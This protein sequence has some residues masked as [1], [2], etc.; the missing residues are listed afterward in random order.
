[1]TSRLRRGGPLLALAALCYL[2]LLATSPGQ[3]V[4]DTKTY[5]YLDPGRLLSR[6]WSMWDAH[7]GMGTVTHQNIGFLW[8]MGP[9]YWAMEHL[10]A[11][12]WVAQRL[13]LGSIMFLAGAGVW[14]LLRT[15]GWRGPSVA[16]AVSAYALSPYLL[17]NAVRISAVLLPFTALPWL[18]GL[19]VRALRTAS[20]RHPAAFALVV[21]T[22]GTSNATA[23]IL[24]GVGPVLWLA[25]SLARRDAPARRVAGVVARVG[26][27]SLG[28]NA[29]WIAGLSVQATNGID[30]LRYTESVQVTAAASSAQE[31]LRGLGYW[32]FYG[33]DAI[34]PWVGPSRPYQTSPWLLAVTFAIP[35]LALTGGAVARWRE[36]SYFVLLATVGLV[37]AVGV[38]PYTDPPP[39]GR[40]AKAFLESDVGM[41]MRS[42]PRAA[43]LVVLAIAVMLGAGLQALSRRGPG[44][45]LPAVVAVVAL[46][47]LALPPLWQRTLAPANV[48]RPEAIPGYWV[49]AGRYLDATDDGTRALVVPGTDFTSYRWGTTFDPVLPGLTDRPLVARELQ[50]MGSPAAWNLL[51]AFDGRLQADLA[52][53]AT[54][55]PIARLMRAGQVL[56]R[57]DL[58]YEH[59][60][61][62]RP[63]R[64][65]ELVRGAPGLGATKSFGPPAPNVAAEPVP[66]LDEREL[67]LD[68]TLP[69]PPPVAVLPVDGAPPIVASQ[70]AEQP[71]VLAGDGDGVVDSAAA[72]LLT[73]TELVHYSAALSG[74][75]LQ[76]ALADGAALVV[77]DT[78][79]RRA[80]RW[81]TIRFTNGY[82]EPAGLR[83][84]RT[85]RSDARL[86]VFPMADDDARTV[87]LHRGGLTANATSYGGRN[88]YLPE[89][90]PANA[91]D[92]DASTAWRT[93]QDDPVRGERLRL[94]TDHP[95]TTSALTFLAPPPPINRWVTRVAL[96]F[97]GGPPLIVDLG[98]A[99]RTAPGQTV[100]IG[101]RTFSTLDIEVLADSAGPQGRYGGLTSTGF[102]EVVVGGLRLDEVVRPPTDLLERAGA[103]SADHPL[104]FVLSRLRSSVTDVERLDEELSLARALDL[105]TRRSFALSGTARLS[106][107]AGDEV[108]DRLLAGPAASP[109]EVTARAS[110]RMAGA[111][112]RAAAAAD[113]DP[114]TA[115]VGAYGNPVGQWVELTTATPT[116]L[117]HLELQLVAD[118]RHSVPTRLRVD[119]D[120]QP[121]GTV[122]VPAVADGDQP[123]TTAAV[124]VPLPGRVTA[125]QLRFTVEAARTHETTDWGTRK[126][127]T[128]PIGIAEVGVPGVE[129][130]APKGPFTTGCRADLLTVGGQPFGVQVTGTVEAAIAGQPL[131][132]T[133]CDDGAVGLP[134]GRTLLR[135]LPGATTGIDVDRL[136]LRSAAGG[137][138][139]AGT[140]P[141]VTPAPSSSPATAVVHQGADHLTVRVTGAQPG[142]AFWFTLGQGWNEGWTAQ[143]AG[144]DLGPP[145]LVDGF[146]NGW[147]IEPTTP[148]FDV[149][150]RFAPQRRVTI[151]LWASAAA[152]LACLAIAIAGTA[153]ARRRDVA[154]APTTMTTSGAAGESTPA[155][156]SLA[157]V[158]G[159]GPP[160]PALGTG[161]VA[162]AAALVGAAL[163]SPVVGV[164]LGVLA[165]V[166]GRGVVPRA[167]TVMLAPA[168]MAASGAYVVL[169]VLRHHTRPGLEWA[170]EMHRAH[171]L[172]WFA[173]LALAVDA[174]VVALRGR[175]R[176]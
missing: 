44:L 59:Y 136:V 47:V 164:L 20:W 24:V 114:T 159:S 138:A 102:A 133:S 7:V 134:P 82:T 158:D 163:V 33:D 30:V 58:Q 129:Q 106:P 118:G 141:V 2:P 162:M 5:L 176:R 120:G 43:P 144:D 157:S 55:A 88:E 50:P 156:V 21:A 113:G 169:T 51:K 71:V 175:A 84:L 81:G 117:D 61:T 85:D 165:A 72:G 28:A 49:Q 172:A 126:I 139:D 46:T 105:P 57:S 132:L 100:A 155:R 97:D 101:A 111:A 135:S 73:G 29:W 79:R 32:F 42:L 123:G 74:P 160:L 170:A 40:A 12:D 11:P 13:W 31:V 15:F 67:S 60:D 112:T 130:P 137:R 19:T 127:R 45:T 99:S 116:T 9:Y 65:W 10:G 173:V 35:V 96:R 87:A 168:A 86:P 54:I 17:S 6:A 70:P 122:D 148:T 145:V 75:Q 80:E 25:W 66:M 103:A 48:R 89:D 76:Q 104:T 68:P 124:T 93:A 150:L 119:A 115:W 121:L 36:R 53:P 143:V 174:V 69:D 152:F 161:L 147:R 1:M 34:G 90:R 16:A 92:G 167:V 8:P 77:T 131:S 108:L 78:N 26:L 39:F 27:L 142:R 37:L 153:L 91:F 3:V 110:S 98:E 63:R 154:A 149:A 125:T 146:A 22:V 95:V 151:A 41:A 109:P 4:S 94:E 128:L 52:E 171:P 107:R 83:P 56:V 38:Y 62:P 166:V 18:I 14:F 140:G 23:I 64:L